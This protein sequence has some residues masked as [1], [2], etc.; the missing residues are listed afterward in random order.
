VPS[1]PSG[2]DRAESSPSGGQTSCQCNGQCGAPNC[3]KNC[4]LAKHAHCR[5][6]S[7]PDAQTAQCCCR[8]PLAGFKFCAICICEAVD[9]QGL[10]CPMPRYARFG[11]RFCSSHHKQRVCTKANY[12]NRYG[13]W[14]LVH[15]WP[16]NLKIVARFGFILRE[17]TP[18]DAVTFVECA[19][20]IVQP[21]AGAVVTGAAL[22]GCFLAQLL[23]WPPV[24]SA[25]GTWMQAEPLTGPTDLVRMYRRA[26]AHA[27]GQD[28]PNMFS[29]MNA[30]GQM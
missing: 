13:L 5:E 16:R 11:K 3:S 4:R 1:A 20:R 23:K 29:V 21:E 26:I 17:L 2:L 27:N 30:G 10:Q 14:A 7:E 6:S 8:P 15:G 25:L 28:W 24:V 18:T 22:C 12:S 9:G 19:K